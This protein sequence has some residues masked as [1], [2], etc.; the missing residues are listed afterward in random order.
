MRKFVLILMVF[1]ITNGFSQTKN[2]AGT[3]SQGASLSKLTVTFRNDSTFEY[4]SNEHPT[5]F[6]W[7]EFSEKGRW[8]VSGDTIILNPQLLKKVYVESEFKEEQIPQSNELVL[9]FNHVKR[10]Y[11]KDGNLI[12]TD[13]VQ[14]RQLDYAF[15][16]FRKKNRTRVVPS[17]SVR[18]GFA[19][20]IPKE[21][22]TPGNTVVIATPAEKVS[23]IFIGCYELQET[24]EFKLQNSNSNRLYF[25]V[26]SNYYPDA[27]IRQVKLLIKNE[28]ALYTSIK[29]NGQL[30]KDNIWIGETDTKLKRLK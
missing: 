5:F 4:I 26:Y 8:A 29:S 30:R 28:N 15:N 25:T 13:T 3:F 1:V 24:K 2:I 21:I 20:Y 19:G 11:D 9:S 17:R 10:F 12:K 27:Q 22:I 23:S 16:E 7:E 6:R 18:C 14:I